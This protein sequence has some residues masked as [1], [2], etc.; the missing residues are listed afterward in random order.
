MTKDEI[1]EGCGNREP[2]KN[3]RGLR[4]CCGCWGRVK[5]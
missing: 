3:W 1:C 5:R 2:T 4:L